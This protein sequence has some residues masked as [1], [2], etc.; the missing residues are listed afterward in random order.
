MP[1]NNTGPLFYHVWP[2]AWGPVG[3][4]A[5]PNGLKRFVLPHYQAN[6]L[7]Q[8]LAWEHSGAA[9]NAEP[10]A[11]LIELTREYF[12]GRTADFNSIECDLPSSKKF[13]GK[14]LRACREIPP[15]Q[16]MSYSAL[17]RKIECPDAARA[18][19]TTLSK[20]AIPL[21]IPCHRIIYADG[22][23]GGFS[24]EGGPKLKQ[25]LLNLEAGLN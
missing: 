8:L 13:A 15:G 10:F 17:A 5:G 7:A 9:K 25:R 14:I 16:T 11:K 18:V 22:R 20:N 1:E 3:A 12:N 2:T 19:A 24:A 23:P 6:Q 21:I 4:V